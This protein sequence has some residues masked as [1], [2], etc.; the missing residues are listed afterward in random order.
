MGGSAGRLSQARQS[1]GVT[2]DVKFRVWITYGSR[3][4]SSMV[5]KSCMHSLGRTFAQARASARDY[6]EPFPQPRPRAAH[7][8]RG[9]SAQAVHRPVHTMTRRRA[10][11]PEDCRRRSIEQSRIRRR[12]LPDWRLLRDSIGVTRA[13]LVRLWSGFGPALV[14]TAL[15]STAL[16]STALVSTELSVRHCQAQGEGAPG[17]RRGDHASWRGVRADASA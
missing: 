2:L 10:R 13:W 3:T 17:E 8:T 9:V 11:Q 14:S 12:S 16:V 1:S 4:L 7:S 6:P 15:V 5:K